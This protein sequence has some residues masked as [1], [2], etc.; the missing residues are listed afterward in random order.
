MILRLRKKYADSFWDT[1]WHPRLKWM[2][3]DARMCVFAEIGRYISIFNDLYLDKAKRRTQN[4]E[5]WRTMT[6][7]RDQIEGNGRKIN[8]P[9]QI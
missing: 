3:V 5:S 4:E 9:E 7:Q 1:R 8:I 2:I 6:E